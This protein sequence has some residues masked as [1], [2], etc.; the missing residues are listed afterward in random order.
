[1]PASRRGEPQRFLQ[2]PWPMCADLYAMRYDRRKARVVHGA[3][4]PEH[5][6]SQADGNDKQNGTCFSSASTSVAVAYKRLAILP[7]QR[8]HSVV[9]R[10]CQTSRVAKA[11]A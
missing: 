1:M 11:P 6:G 5:Q 4:W 8:A 3:Y 7:L 2:M 9:D 10:V